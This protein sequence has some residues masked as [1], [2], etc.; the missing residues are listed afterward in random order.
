MEDKSNDGDHDRGLFHE[1]FHPEILACKLSG[2]QV[3]LT[4]MY[5]RLYVP[6]H[7]QSI[8]YLPA[9]ISTFICLFIVYIY[10]HVCFMHNVMLAY[11]RVIDVQSTGTTEFRRKISQKLQNLVSCIS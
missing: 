11:I 6:A 7:V 5:D 9:T 10:M 2:R 4:S 3:G 8:F 1:T